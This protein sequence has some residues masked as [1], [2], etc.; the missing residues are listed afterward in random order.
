MLFRVG[1]RPERYIESLPTLHLDESDLIIR[2][3]RIP[4]VNSLILVNYV[5]RFGGRSYNIQRIAKDGNISNSE[6]YLNGES[7]GIGDDP[8][9]AIY[10]DRLFIIYCYPYLDV[11]RPASSPV[12]KLHVVA[13]SGEFESYNIL[14]PPDLA[15]GKNWVLMESKG[16]YPDILHSHSPLVILKPSYVD[17]ESMAVRYTQ[18]EKVDSALPSNQQDNFCFARGAGNVV[19]CGKAKIGATHFNYFQPRLK[20]YHVHKPGMFLF[21]QSERPPKIKYLP[22]CLSG[23]WQY[24]D[25]QHIEV[26]GDYFNI[27][28]GLGN[29]SEFIHKRTYGVIVIKRERLLSIL[30]DKAGS[31]Q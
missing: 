26:D 4:N 12:G 6:V 18:A 9:T 22:L 7:L 8:F 14:F 1:R 27:H 23:S 19:T 5:V 20:Y 2:S 30:R 24:V 25:P 21:D 16:G 15:V 11:R 3:T 17:N 29:G 28:C 13:M 10:S 31:P